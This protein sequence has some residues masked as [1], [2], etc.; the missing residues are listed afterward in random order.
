ML[1]HHEYI[2]CRTGWSQQHNFK[3]HISSPTLPQDKQYFKRSKSVLFSDSLYWCHLLSSSQ[4]DKQH[5]RKFSAKTMNYVIRWVPISSCE[6]LHLSSEHPLQF[7]I[8]IK[9]YMHYSLYLYIIH[10]PWIW[11]NRYFKMI[12][13]YTTEQQR[14]V[15]MHKDSGSILSL[16]RLVS[17]I[18]ECWAK[19][20]Q[21]WSIHD[22]VGQKQS[23]S[24]QVSL[25]ALSCMTV[26]VRAI[27]LLPYHISQTCSYRRVS[28]PRMWCQSLVDIT[29]ILLA[30]TG[31]RITLIT[32]CLDT[33]QP[34][35]WR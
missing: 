14:N 33:V 2:L 6:Q 34:W 24:N 31:S 18:Q 13:H 28:S 11:Q 5:L 32:A 22:N 17:F 3:F 27:K 19:Y 4:W 16:S 1:V 29:V 23:K 12:L 20:V 10:T 15:C 7:T 8:I 9:I 35:R 21:C 25:C 30:Y 26:S